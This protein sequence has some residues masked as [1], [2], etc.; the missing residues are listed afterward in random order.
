MLGVVQVVRLVATGI[1][2]YF[3]D[4]VNNSKYFDLEAK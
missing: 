3:V 1:D 2:L 4:S